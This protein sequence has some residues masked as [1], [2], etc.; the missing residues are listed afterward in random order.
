MVGE[1]GA[2]AAREAELGIKPGPAGVEGRMHTTHT[3]VSPAAHATLKGPPL[4]FPGCRGSMRLW[5]PE[6]EGL[7]VSQ[8]KHSLMPLSFQAMFLC[9][10][11]P[12]S[13]K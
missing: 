13:H 2:T 8:G 11:P 9:A 5:G 10:L 6:T 1:D 7:G 3:R 12:E 4:D